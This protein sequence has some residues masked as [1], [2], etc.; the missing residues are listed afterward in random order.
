MEVHR[1]RFVDYTPAS[2][3]ALAFSPPSAT[4]CQ[5]TTARTL[6]ACA[7]SNGDI[8]IWNPKD[9][10]NLEK[11]IP[12]GSNM[13]IEALTWVHQTVLTDAEDYDDPR[14][15]KAA[16]KEL[17]SESPRLFSAGLNSI[18]TEWD[19]DTMTS[20]RSIDS[21]GGAVWCMAT[22]HSGTFIAIG[23]EDGC[24]RLFNVSDGGLEFTKSFDK[25][26]GRILSIAWSADDKYI[27]TGSSD[28]SLRKWDVSQG[29][30]VSRMTVDR[31]R[32]EDTIV[33]AVN[34]L[35]DGTIVSGDSLG[36]VKFWDGNLGT[37]KHT[38]NAHGADVLCMA[39]MRDGSTV[40]TSGVDRKVNQFKLVESQMRKRKTD[41]GD[42]ANVKSRWVLTGSR[43]YHS[44]DVRAMA[45][46]ENRPV[47]ALVTGGVDL[48]LV[49]CPAAEF[50]NINQRRL[51]I[52]P[53][54]PLLSMSRSE[55]LVLCRFQNSLKLWR[56]G[57]SSPP[58]D[59]YWQMKVGSQ[60]RLLQPQQAL[61]ELSLKNDCNLI[62]SAL[63]ENG[64]WIAAATVEEVKLFHLQYN[65]HN[66]VS[67]QKV[68]SLPNLSGPDAE[69]MGA[70]QLLFTPD[71]TKLIVASLDSTVAILDLSQWPGEIKVL[72]RFGQHQGTGD[73]GESE[74]GKPSSVISL[75]VSADGQWMA[76][77]DL[78]NRVHVFNLDTLQHHLTLPRYGSTHTALSFHP[79]K[80]NTLVVALAN[81]ELY[82]HDLETRKLT[83][84][85]RRCSHRLP[86]KF[87]RLR[88]KIVGIAYN[89]ARPST[90]MAWGATFMCQVD[91]D[92]DVGDR[93]SEINVIKRKRME[94]AGKRR[95]EKNRKA[96]GGN[97]V[98]RNRPET[99]GDEGAR[100]EVDAAGDAAGEKM[101]TSEGEGKA[102]SKVGREGYEG[103]EEG[104]EEDIHNFRL[105]HK[106]Q[107]LLFLDF[108]S[109]ESLVVIERPFFDILE[110]LPPSF[111]RAKYGT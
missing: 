104:E 55:R 101:E 66:Q 18:I 21:H 17:A 109:G 20:L 92:R 19:L 100:M 47:N 54:K 69:T 25:Q 83:D 50:P 73:G 2:I 81:N 64:R 14:E 103:E 79:Y 108:L 35:P 107:P 11:I 65:E 31:V 78:L 5:G 41:G 6:L 22:N 8:E 74:Q 72:R 10:W 9:E 60:L 3:N 63:S 13:S 84:W 27:I 95:E 39:A 32:G 88:D 102:D 68:R 45:L 98:K 85:S 48:S 12:G 53:Q 59:P 58:E 56:M 26:K 46:E 90:L 110:K 105:L 49:V 61:A 94:M 33:W 51:P 82:L 77:G 4:D 16:L 62:A 111:Y 71:S 28:S 67:V 44:H 40:Y 70:H 7:R 99:S 97:K 42:E 34:V 52:F 86:R 106:Y 80:P 96:K 91:L 30:V 43:R 1:C 38:F 89:P 24:V 36:H 87:L 15:L 37:M 57:Q 76:T 93:N 75:A 23:C 29:R